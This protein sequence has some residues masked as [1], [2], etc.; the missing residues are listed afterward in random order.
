MLIN[1]NYKPMDSEVQ[2]I[3]EEKN[4]KGGR[5]TKAE[6]AEAV[7]FLAALFVAIPCVFVVD[8]SRAAQAQ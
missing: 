8:P 6:E 1:L 3:T 2:A 5:E 4:T 7:P